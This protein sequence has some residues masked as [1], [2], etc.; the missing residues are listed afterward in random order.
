VA[1]AGT[2]AA[3]IA[4]TAPVATAG[5]DVM[6]TI[7]GVAGVGSGQ[8]LIG[9]VG[10]PSEG[11]QVSVMGGAVGARGSVSYTQGIGYGL[12]QVLT[13]LLGSDGA[14]QAR[15]DGLQSTIKDMDKRKESMQQRLDL[16]QAA[17]LKQFNALDTELAQLSS[18][19]T[20]LSQQLASL[21]GT[22]GSTK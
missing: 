17:Y 13:N 5:L 3:T 14:V 15:T 7:G 1:L 2:A 16:V 18:M 22:S 9:A 11:L 8:S 12:D 10:S 6:G 4:G 19:S 21:P 20:Y